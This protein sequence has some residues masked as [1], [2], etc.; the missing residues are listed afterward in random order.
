MNSNSCCKMVKICLVNF[1]LVFKCSVCCKVFTFEGKPN[2][3]IIYLVMIIN[4]FGRLLF[5][6]R[7]GNDSDELCVC[8]VNADASVQ[9]LLNDPETCQRPCSYRKTIAKHSLP[10]EHCSVTK[11]E[12]CGDCTQNCDPE[13]YAF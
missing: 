3:I 7:R 6:R 1:T 10:G 9:G 12:G 2:C 8:Y 5:N 4:C 11:E 13:K